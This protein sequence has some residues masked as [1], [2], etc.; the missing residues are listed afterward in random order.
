[1]KI[2]QQAKSMRWMSDTGR[3]FGGTV[4]EMGRF[5]F[6]PPANDRGCCKKIRAVHPGELPATRLVYLRT[7]TPGSTRLPGPSSVPLPTRRGQM[8]GLETGPIRPHASAPF[9]LSAPNLPVE[10]AILN[11]LRHVIASQDF[12]AS[13]I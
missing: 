3:S 6:R 1:M 8:K 2:S 12:R 13:Q 9:L 11:R 7:I 10:R 5:H 4:A